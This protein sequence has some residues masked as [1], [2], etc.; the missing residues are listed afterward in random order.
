MD[1]ILKDAKERLLKEIDDLKRKPT[2]TAQELE[3][4]C[5]AL[6]GVHYICEIAKIEMEMGEDSEEGYS[7][8]HPHDRYYNIH[9]YGD[10]SWRNGRRNAM[11]Q[12]S[13]ADVKRH[14][15]DG[16]YSMM[17]DADSEAERGAFQDCINKLKG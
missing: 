12:Y 9:S 15:I 2:M 11:G 5:T 4:F 16:L 14:M 13:R 1:K 17:G 8:Y 10:A 3:S 7:N 6:N